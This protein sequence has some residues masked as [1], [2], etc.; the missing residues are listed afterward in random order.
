MAYTCPNC[1]AELASVPVR[2]RTCDSIIVICPYCR[3]TGKNASSEEEY[4]ASCTKCSGNGI[5]DDRRLA[6]RDH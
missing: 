4:A 2:C 3:G 5:V 6:A 1:S